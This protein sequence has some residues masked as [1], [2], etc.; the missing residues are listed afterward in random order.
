MCEKEIVSNIQMQLLLFF[1]ECNSVDAEM[2]ICM[3]SSDISEVRQMEASGLDLR[4]LDNAKSH[5]TGEHMDED[6]K[7]HMYIII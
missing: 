1:V 7:V 4:T 2:G 5:T 3:T 6:E